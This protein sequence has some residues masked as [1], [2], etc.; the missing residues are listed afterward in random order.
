LQRL[1]LP[2][3]FQTIVEESTDPDTLKLAVKL[4]AF[5]DNESRNRSMKRAKGDLVAWLDAHRIV[6]LKSQAEMNDLMNAE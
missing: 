2:S 5:F 1:A 4:I 3:R 6:W